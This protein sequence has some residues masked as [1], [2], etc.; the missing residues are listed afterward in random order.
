MD[1]RPDV[2]IR[3]GTI[4]PWAVRLIPP[5]Q[6]AQHSIKAFQQVVQAPGPAV[7]AEMQP[8]EFAAVAKRVATAMAAGKKMPAGTDP[9]LILAARRIIEGKPFAIESAG[10]AAVVQGRVSSRG[11]V[12]AQKRRPAWTARGWRY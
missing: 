6:I 5:G 12:V 11:S 1:I 7:K 2:V 3:S 10:R 9:K 8:E 4:Q